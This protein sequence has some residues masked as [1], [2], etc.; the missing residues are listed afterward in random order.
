MSSDKNII[1]GIRAN[2]SLKQFLATLEENQKK[3]IAPLI[4][5]S[6]PDKLRKA[7]YLSSGGKFLKYADFLRAFVIK[8]GYVPIHPVVTLN[9]YISSV[10]HNYNK[11]EIMQDCFTLLLKSDELWVFE[12]KLPTFDKK[13]LVTRLKPIF[14]FPEGVIAEIYFWLANKPNSPIRFFTWQD[15]GIA[16]YTPDLSWSLVPE[17]N[18]GDVTLGLRNELPQRFGIIDLGSST[19]KLTVCSFDVD[20]K[21]EILDKKSITVN[22]AEGFFDNNELQKPAIARTLEAIIDC[23]KEALG[24]GVLDIKIVGTGI[25]RKAN[26]INI[27]TKEIKEKTDLELKI[28]SGKD[29]AE[30]IYKAVAASFKLK[31]LRLAVVNA[32]GGSTSIMYGG[33]HK[34]QYNSLPLGISDLNEKY[35]E[36]YPISTTQYK[37][38]KKS[39]RKMLEENIKQP[40]ECDFLVYTG[41]ELDYMIIT[42]F[43]LKD[44][45]GSLVHPKKISLKKFNEYAGKMRSMTQEKLHA[46]MPANPKWMN[47]A[48]SS[49]TILE[50][51]AEFLKIETI[52]PSNKNLNDGILLTMIE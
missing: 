39:V 30:L 34:T 49:N 22:L 28:L 10:F 36:R 41:G 23:Q 43:P 31:N 35:V 46:F 21:V 13:N 16:K 33:N 48:I 40:P 2:L 52:I 8:S 14:D 15:I 32:G 42:G 18:K 1:K 24:F 25:L 44:Y 29:E 6:F 4:N 37:K 3:D 38:M 19:V 45:S 20:K 12:E 51:I 5:S 47:G 27:F 17:K 50:T 26:N 9:Y 7:V 11:A